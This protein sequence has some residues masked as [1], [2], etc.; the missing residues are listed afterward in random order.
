MKKIEDEVLKIE[1]QFVEYLKLELG[2]VLD[3]I[4]EGDCIESIPIYLEL[5]GDRSG[6]MAGGCNLSS[7]MRC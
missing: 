4:G 1:N 3:D 2:Q 5:C 6:G 7:K